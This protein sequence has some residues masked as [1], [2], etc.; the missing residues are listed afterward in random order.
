MGELFGL[1]EMKVWSPCETRRSWKSINVLQHDF[2]LPNYHIAEN[3]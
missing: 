2:E 3:I 1:M